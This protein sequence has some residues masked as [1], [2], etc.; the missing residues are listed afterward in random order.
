MLFT[1]PWAIVQTETGTRP[2][3]Q[4]RLQ[5]RVNIERDGFPVLALLDSLVRR[6]AH[7]LEL[8]GRRVNHSRP[9][10]PG[11]GSHPQC[12]DSVGAGLGLSAPLSISI[13][14]TCDF[15]PDFRYAAW[16]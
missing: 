9:G 5:D 4:G 12:A 11:D 10:L 1:M 2:E 14:S 6:S 8:V 7:P 16:R 15:T 3:V 13:N